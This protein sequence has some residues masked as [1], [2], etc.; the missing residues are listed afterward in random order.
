MLVNYIRMRSISSKSSIKSITTEQGSIE[1]LKEIFYDALLLDYGFTIQYIGTSMA[2]DLGYRPEKLIGQ[3]VMELIP[4]FLNQVLPLLQQGIFGQKEIQFKTNNESFISAKLSAFYSYHLMNISG[5]I[6][7]RYENV[8]NADFVR[9][10]L[11]AKTEEMDH[12]IYQA[13]HSLRGPLATIRG[14]ISIAKTEKN[15]EQLSFI[16]QKMEEFASRLDTKLS[17]I[18]CFA[19]VDRAFGI[20]TGRL[21]A[22]KLELALKLAVDLQLQNT[23]KIRVRCDVMDMP[24]IRLNENLVEVLLVNLVVFVSRFVSKTSVVVMVRILGDETEIQIAVQTKGFLIDVPVQEIIAGGHGYGHLLE[25]PDLINLYSA[26][27]IIFK[28]KGKIQLEV[29]QN[30][31]TVLRISVPYNFISISKK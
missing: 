3:P 7:L 25:R 2:K 5:F 1:N 15:S 30:E 4:S 22:T 6:V 14:L 21:D 17:K 20:P 13:S 31:E 19:E 12:F 28:L 10:Q 29:A 9:R 16:Y 27:K 11:V 8:E 24:R 18:I 23:K 26:Q